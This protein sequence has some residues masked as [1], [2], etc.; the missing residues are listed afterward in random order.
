MRSGKIRQEPE[1]VVSMLDH[2]EQ[3][4]MDLYDPIAEPQDE[5]EPPDPSPL[6]TNSRYNLRPRRSRL[7]ALTD[8]QRFRDYEI[9]HCI[10]VTKARDLYGDAAAESMLN[11]LAKLNRKSTMVPVDPRN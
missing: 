5:P 10:S 6:P 2:Q 3:D 7:D 8:N 1:H 4:L 9:R 11:E